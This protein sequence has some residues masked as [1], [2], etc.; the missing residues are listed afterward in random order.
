MLLVDRRTYTNLVSRVPDLL[1]K[2]P[3]PTKPPTV[4]VQTLQFMLLLGYVA[5]IFITGRTIWVRTA[6]W[7]TL[8]PG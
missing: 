7:F 4:A 5:L 3:D 8:F 1:G 2:T 6:W